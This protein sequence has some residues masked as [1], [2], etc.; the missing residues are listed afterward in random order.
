MW[1][2]T[3]AKSYGAGQPRVES[4]EHE[5]SQSGCRQ[6]RCSQAHPNPTGRFCAGAVLNAEVESATSSHCLYDAASHEKTRNGTQPNR[7][8]QLCRH[9][10][11]PQGEMKVGHREAA[12]E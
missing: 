1:N 9:I 2:A 3:A 8:S 6:T 7:S 4:G 10:A 12:N 11:S 5:Q